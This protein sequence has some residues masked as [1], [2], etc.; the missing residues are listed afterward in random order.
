M[1]KTIPDTRMTVLVVEDQFLVRVF[2]ADSLA[3]AGFKVLEAANADQALIAL[4][5]RPD[6]RVV[7]TDVEM[8][9]SMNGYELA[10]IVRERWPGVQVIVTSGLP[11]P[12]T[13]ELSEE[14][15][16]V[17]KPY[18]SATI[19]S[20]IWQMTTEAEPEQPLPEL[21][22]A[23]GNRPKAPSHRNASGPRSAARPCHRSD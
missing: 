19:V 4:E 7:M 5:A 14:F 2:A 11:H 3:E 18:L 13:D 23:A 10:Q 9:G 16:F 1:G 12:R 20:L 8:P 21:N 6:I 15:P 17:A 22:E